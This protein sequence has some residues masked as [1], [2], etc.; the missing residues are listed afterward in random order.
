MFTALNCT[1]RPKIFY[2][3]DTSFSCHSYY[4]A[5]RDTPNS[6]ILLFDEIQNQ[7]WTY[8]ESAQIAQK[9]LEDDRL[10]YSHKGKAGLT[11]SANELQSL[12][13]SIVEQGFSVTLVGRD[14]KQVA[15][16]CR[17]FCGIK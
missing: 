5:K 7:Y 15:D 8:V 13:R 12:V 1:G 11:I 10:Y 17:A 4:A 2:R 14:A 6:V 3:T 9:C 16:K